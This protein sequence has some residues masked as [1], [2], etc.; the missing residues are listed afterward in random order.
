MGAATMSLVLSKALK[1][2]VPEAA[3]AGARVSWYQG[4]DELMDAAA[5]ADAVWVRPTDLTSDQ[6]SRLVGHAKALRWLHFSRV[7]VDA[8]PLEQIAQRGILLTNGRGLSARPM[9]EHAFPISHQAGQNGL[10]HFL[11]DH[12]APKDPCADSIFTVWLNC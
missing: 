9:A 6:W 10:V 8:L 3:L 2:T 7:G 1:D 11:L 4:F 12:L 5:G